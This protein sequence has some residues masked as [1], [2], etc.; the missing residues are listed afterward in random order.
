MPKRDHYRPGTP[1]WIELATPDPAA[2]ERFYGPLMGWS[3]HTEPAGEDATYTMVLR[4]GEPV[5][6]LMTQPPEQIEMGLP[7]LWNTYVTV[8]SADEAAAR[9]AGAGGSVMAPPFDV[10]DVGRM[11]VVV[12][13]AGAVTCVW[14]PRAHIGAHLVNEPGAFTWAELVTPD[15]TGA[16][17]FYGQVFGWS[18]TATEMPPIGTMTF[19]QLDGD[20][21]ASALT[22]PDVPPHWQVYL[23]VGDCD[24]ACAAVEAGGG[25]VLADPVDAPPGRMA[26]VADPA[27]AVFSVIALAQPAA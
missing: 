14:E 15:Q 6:G 19:F 22:L 21:I 17:A 11:A 18:A 12:D 13:P 4:D 16:A 3:F 25:S 7:A 9:A 2:A 20:D 26:P 23:G 1:S 8:E 10:M 27:G 5:A 24:A